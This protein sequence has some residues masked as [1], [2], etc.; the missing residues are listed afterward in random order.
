MTHTTNLNQYQIYADLLGIDVN[1]ID[2]VW[3]E[4][5]NALFIDLA[6]DASICINHSCNYSNE[7]GTTV[8]SDLRVK[9]AT[10]LDIDYIEH[11]Y[12]ISK[13]TA[14]ELLQ[15]YLWD[16]DYVSEEG[17]REQLED[18]ADWEAT[19]RETARWLTA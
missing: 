12:P 10:I 5:D 16:N 2:D 11:D 1:Q 9:P 3:L 4:L 15:T 7:Y 19:C 13:K 18:E 14:L 17:Y 8:Y 6:S